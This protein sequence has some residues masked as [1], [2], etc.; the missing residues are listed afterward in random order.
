M[1]TADEL[2]LVEDALRKAL[3]SDVSLLA[4]A[5]DRIVC[6]GGKRL[7]PKIVLLSYKAAGGDNIRQVVPLAAAVELLHT[8]SLIHDDINDRSDMRRGQ[9]S[10]NAR[11]GDGLAL[12]VG[13]FV[14]VRLLSLIAVLDSRAIHVL[15]DCCTA[16]V[17]GETLQM[18]HLGDTAMAEETYLGIV[19]LKTAALFSACGE[20]GGV[21]AGGSEDRASALRDYGLNLGI[22]FQIRDDTLDLTGKS[23]KLG[24]PVASDLEQ[25]KMSLA[26]LFALRRSDEAEEV[27]LSKDPAQAMRLLHHTG[28]LEY[29]MSRTREYSE[30]AKE[31]LSILPRSEARA[32]LSRLADF[33]YVRDQ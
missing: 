22:A 30:R 4:K 11:W 19:G 2:D 3:T 29:A 23:G 21:L 5:S 1:I 24:K 20:L 16:I 32:E 15:A 9:P 14:F 33:A 13:D 25:G 27:L 17:E 18:L 31:A 8:A 26:T 12:L 7:R 28:A 6:S 10:V